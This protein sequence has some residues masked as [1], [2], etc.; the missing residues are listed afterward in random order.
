MRL[1]RNSELPIA[2]WLFR[3]LTSKKKKRLTL[4]STS[5]SNNKKYLLTLAH[6]PTKPSLHNHSSLT[7]S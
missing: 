3:S 6:L 7:R 1:L 2:S 5:F 4:L